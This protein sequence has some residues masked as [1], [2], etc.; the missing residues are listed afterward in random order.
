MA[1]VRRAAHG[2]HAAAAAATPV[3]VAGRGHFTEIGAILK[4]VARRIRGAATTGNL[5]GVMVG[6]GAFNRIEL[7]PAFLLQFREKLGDVENFERQGPAQDVGAGPA[8]HAVGMSAFRDDQRPGA[9]FLGGCNQLFNGVF[10]DVRLAGQESE[11]GGFVALGA[12]GPV[13]A[14]LV[15]QPGHGDDGFRVLHHFDGGNGQQHLGLVPVQRQIDFV[16]VLQPLHAA[17]KHRR[18]HAQ[19][20]AL[21]QHVFS[22]FEQVDRAPARGREGLAGGG[23]DGRDVDAHRADLGAASAHGAAVE[24]EFFPFLQIG[25]GDLGAAEHAPGPLGPAV[26]FGHWK[27]LVSR[28]VLRII[29]HF[30]KVA[31]GRTL[32]A[33][34]AGL[35]VGGQVSAV[36]GQE[37]VGSGLGVGGL[38]GVL[39]A[40][41]TFTS[42]CSSPSGSITWTAQAMQ[43]SKL[44]IVRWIS[45]G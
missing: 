10:R 29:G 24:Q 19:R 15:H 16:I 27:Q 6:E 40:H 30:V 32:P 42:I 45:R 20:A 12:E 34:N 44:W 9:D 36:Q 21:G 1:Q 13:D 41:V 22:R 3:E 4:Q 17:V 37:L 38:P 43:G 2:L 31:G 14:C 35:E 26:R 5:A 8:Q 23:H 33:V 39:I 28:G 7:E 11:I 18:C 25:L